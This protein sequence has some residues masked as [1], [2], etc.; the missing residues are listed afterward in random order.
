MFSKVLVANRGEIALR[1]LR[2]CRDLGVA[3]VA[4]YS[5]AD[6]GALHVEAADEA[7]PIGPP[8]AVDS[9]L[10]IPRILDA[11]R[12][13]GADA[14][15]P[16]YGFL[17]ESAEFARAVEDAGLTF[18]GPRPEVIA[19]MGDKVAAR[20]I[21]REAGLPVV[22][23]SEGAVTLEEAREVAEQIGYPVLL[24]AVAG[25][26]GIGMTVARDSRELE[27][28]FA[29]SERRATSAFGDGALYVERLFERPRHVEIQVL[30]DAHGHHLHLFERECSIQRRHQKVLEEAPSPLFAGGANDGLARRM[31]E[32][33]VA[34]ARRVEY[35]GAGT[36]EC[37]VDGDAFYFLEMN[38]R[39]Q[40]EHPCTEL[41][42]GLDLVH[43]QLRIAA[44]EALDFEQAD[45]RR[46][47]HAIEMRIYAEDPARS[48][49]PSPGTITRMTVPEGEGIRVDA[50]YRE[51]DT[52]TP[53]YDPLVAK[54]VVWAPDRAAAIARGRDA[55]RRFE[56]EGIKTNLPT[57]QAILE[58][59][60]FLGGA[61]STRF[62]EDLTSSEP[63]E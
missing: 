48:F 10:Q 19:R 18:I 4:V 32:A 35:L 16:G 7:V 8:R 2:A 26:G 61:L 55:L 54:L 63:K 13:S 51:G 56:I 62:L 27:K 46:S 37:L 11:A 25:G 6:A 50:G 36:V 58:A 40:V 45:V 49:F 23:G 22:P 17:A 42:C 52:V 47:G 53:Y 15:H 14:I 44:G 29:Q 20:R 9:Y 3:T 31:R 33:A 34:L 41:T 30:S 12:A 38:T 5:E 39:L 28:A 24:K 21:A 1:V 57:H 43:W 59:E 60:A